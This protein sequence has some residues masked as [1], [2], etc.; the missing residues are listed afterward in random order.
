[1][2][3][4]GSSA[5]KESFCN[6]GDPGSIPESGSSLG[7]GIGYPL[8][9]SWTSL[10][11][12]L[13]KN[14][15]A[16]RETWVWS[17]GWEDP[18]EEGMATHSSILAW[19]I[20]M[21]RGIWWATVHGAAKSRKPLS[22]WAHSTALRGCDENDFIYLHGLPLKTHN[23]S[24]SMRKAQTNRNW[25]TAYK[26]PEQDSIKN[27]ENLRNAHSQEKPKETRWLNVT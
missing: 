2:G 22:D 1:M 25:G 6:S 8:Q 9:Y 14:L 23:P 16:I 4:P 13:V 3:F 18:L 21:D 19:R 5:G 11:A 12:Q 7:E 15:P 17:L 27:K 10:V 20:P 26:I 24:G